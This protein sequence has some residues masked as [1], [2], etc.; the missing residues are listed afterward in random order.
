MKWALP[1]SL[2]LV[3]L[4]R[5]LAAQDGGFLYVGSVLAGNSNETS[6]RVTLQRDLTGPVGFDGSLLL[7]PGAR[8][9]TGSL[10]GGG[11]DITILSGSHNA[12][13]LFAGLAGG[14]GFGGQKRLWGAISAGIR[15]PVVILGPVRLM[16]EGRYRDYTFSGR[17][18]V[19][20]GVAL[21]YRAPRH[22]TPPQPESAG[23]FVLPPIA[24]ILR[25]RGIPE[26]KAQ[27]L[28][29][30]V[31]SAVDEMGQPYVWGGTGNGNGGFDCSGLIQ[32]AYNRYGIAI[33][34][35]S[36]GQATAG[37]A[38]RRDPDALLPGDILVFSD[39]GDEQP[40]HV[41][42]YVGEG[43]FIHSASNGVRLSRL[44]EDDSE[45]RLWLRRW[46]GVRRIVE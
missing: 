17:T 35:T 22:D 1:A 15:M 27:L 25:A 28:A 5:P 43:K 11:G 19:E 23:L 44:A 33:P 18:G 45:G 13:T 16:A 41:G 31:S 7:L 6:W 29:N 40:T 2:A 38:I 10:L 3:V 36:A 9:A 14:I 32:F 42:L 30:V 34:R 20:I 39:R 4:A 21:G 26:E 12:P 46:V 37:V 8:P 24:E